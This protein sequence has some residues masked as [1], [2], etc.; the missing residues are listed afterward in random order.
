MQKYKIKLFFSALKSAAGILRDKEK[1]KELLE[2]VRQKAIRSLDILNDRMEDINVLVRLIK[3]WSAGTYR[4]IPKKAIVA[5]TS[6]LLYFLNP[7][8]LI[9]DVIPFSGFLDDVAV[10]TYVLAS[11][12][13][14]IERFLSWE[15][16]RRKNSYIKI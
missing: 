1:T 15:N 14:E 16:S 3:A 10:I 12:K 7:F 11:L 2:Q 8:D 9:P 13:S 5:A 6:S 4:Q